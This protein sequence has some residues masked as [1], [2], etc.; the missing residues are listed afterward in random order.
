MVGAAGIGM[1]GELFDINAQNVA[2]AQSLLD[3][4]DGSQRDEVLAHI[5]SSSPIHLADLAGDIARFMGVD[6]DDIPDALNAFN[7]L[8][9]DRQQ[10]VF[11]TIE[12]DG[13]LSSL[14]AGHGF[15]AYVAGP[16]VSNVVASPLSSGNADEVADAD[17]SAENVAGLSIAVTF[18]KTMDNSTTPVLTLSDGNSSLTLGNGSWNGAETVFTQEYIVSDEGVDVEGITVTVSGALDALGNPQLLQLAPV[19]AAPEAEFNI[20][21]LN[22]TAS[23]LSI[24]VDDNDQTDGDAV[25]SF[26]VSTT[27]VD[28]GMIHVDMRGSEFA[29]LD[30]IRSSY[31]EDVNQAITDLGVAKSGAESREQTLQTANQNLSNELGNFANSDA[32][33]AEASRLEGLRDD[34]N[35]LEADANAYSDALTA[36]DAIAGPGVDVDLHDGTV[37]YGSRGNLLADSNDATEDANELSSVLNSVDTIDVDA[38]LDAGQQD[39]SR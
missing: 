35:D 4:M 24:V 37:N 3:A 6:P 20:D 13:G 8:S 34:Y 10:L 18:D 38:S 17:T 14:G 9:F 2:D 29:A 15:E 26:T 5:Q 7:A 27:D 21:T 36:K 22:P 11:E 19:A 30:A 23:T 33:E 31:I 16:V 32:V 1:S 28:P 12:S 39:G 25:S